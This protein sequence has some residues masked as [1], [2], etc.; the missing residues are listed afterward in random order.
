MDLLNLIKPNEISLVLP[1]QKQPASN[2]HT[3]EPQ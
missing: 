2:Q 3:N 1:S